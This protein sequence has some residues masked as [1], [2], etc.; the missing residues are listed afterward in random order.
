MLRSSL[1]LHPPGGVSCLHSRRIRF[2]HCKIR[3]PSPLGR[4]AGGGWRWDE[5]HC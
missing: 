4:R 3:L 2:F 1:I 5:G